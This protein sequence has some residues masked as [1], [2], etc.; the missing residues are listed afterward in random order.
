MKDETSRQQSGHRPEFVIS[1]CSLYRKLNGNTRIVDLRPDAAIHNDFIPGAVSLDYAQLVKKIGDA[2]G[3]LPDQEDLV[4]LIEGLGIDAGA[5]VVAYDE[6][7]GIRATRLLWT[8]YACGHRNL[9]LLDGGINAWKSSGLPTSATQAMVNPRPYPCT[10]DET[11]VADMAYVMHSLENSNQCI[12]DVRSLGEYRGT[13]LRAERGGH[14]P[15]ALHFE[16][17]QA[18]EADGQLRHPDH[19][20]AEL[21]EAGVDPALEVIPYCQSNRRSAHM[22]HILKWLGYP[23]V[24]AY[25]GSWSEWGNSSSAPVET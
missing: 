13:D 22:F 6:D 7:T 10:I 18:L 12:L 11:A 2:Q 9:A 8:L 14:V 16:W 4:S 24:R 3:M 23:K 15:G 5:Q 1:A 25:A 21:L 17:K 19:I 20:K